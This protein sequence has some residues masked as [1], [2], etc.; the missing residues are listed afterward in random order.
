[1]HTVRVVGQNARLLAGVLW[2]VCALGGPRS[3]RASDTESALPSPLRPDD[4][5]A[6][7]H[8]HRA[9]I[10]AARAKAAAAAAVPRMVTALPD[11]MV[12]AGLDHLPFKL[13]GADWSLLVQQDFPFGGTLGARGRA[14][15]AEARA[16]SAD[17]QTVQ[18]EVEY[19]A[20]GVYL[21]WVELQR[22][23]AVVEDQ[24][25]ISRQILAVTNIRL[26][27]SQAAS[28]EAVRA[29]TEI[30]RLEG[31]RS[32]INA[33]LAALRSMLNAA[34]GRSIP[35]EL[36]P[37]ELTIPAADPLPSAE[38]ARIALDKRPELAAMRARIGKAGANVDVMRS[39]FN[40]MAFVRG[41]YAQTMT[42]GP[43][44]MLM[45]GV[46]L[47]VWRDKLNAGVTEARS[48]RSMAEA[49]TDAM[50]K[51][52][53][54]EV[55]AAR[56]Q[57]IAARIRLVTARDK[58]LPLAKQALLLTLSS[59]GTGQMPLVSVLDAARM[60]REA[61]MEEV[62]AEVKLATAWARLGRALGVAKVGAP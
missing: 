31:E 20:L 59:Y 22:M 44:V 48:M 26:A 3:A 14:A 9:E 42:D 57:V 21:M 16:A 53:E 62:V 29:Q 38:L 15:D 25:V 39:M 11:P 17:A 30:A 61:R 4:V 56:E 6:Y 46:T 2:L 47:P 35:A 50:T 60:I 13:H 43:G 1:M 23:T 12:M 37:A 58:V 49:E 5:F 52:I 10:R 19:Q 34:L 7:V 24:L 45:V 32:A 40:P 54:G 51:M 27:V 18:L 55:G 33:E 8:A 36:P 28:A 41:G